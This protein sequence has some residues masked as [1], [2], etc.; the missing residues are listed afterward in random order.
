MWNY[1]KNTEMGNTETIF[2]ASLKRENG[3]DDRE[4]IAY[5][6]WRKIYK[7]PKL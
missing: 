6:S 2:Y 4:P 3:I 7:E 1:K 5:A